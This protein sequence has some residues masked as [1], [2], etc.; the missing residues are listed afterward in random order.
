MKLYQF[1][2]FG[3]DGLAPVDV[4]E[5]GPGPRDVLVRW[6]AW[7]LNSRDLLLI[8]GVL[9]PGLPLPFTPVSDAAGEVVSVGKEV[10]TWKS[11]DR[12]VSHFF[13]DWQDG[14]GTPENRAAALA[15]SLPGLLAECSVLPERAL[16]PLPSHMSYA[17]GAT[18]PIAGVTAWNALF[19]TNQAALQPG[20]TVLLQGTGGVSIFA[21]Q[22]AHAAGLRTI[23]TSSSDEKLARARTL[24]ADATI[25]YRTTPA[26]AEQTRR[27]TGGRGVDLV[28]DIGGA[29][30]LNH[31]FRAARMGGSVAIVGLTGGPQVEIDV[32]QV[33]SQLIRIRGVSVGSRTELLAALHAMEVRKIHPIVDRQF[34]F[35]ETRAAFLHFKTGVHFGKIVIVSPNGRFLTAPS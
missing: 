34:G 9:A 19:P 8:E 2:R 31:S 10:T 26:W 14:E 28:V 3:I 17:E 29:S 1:S 5:T 12:V 33:F 6:Q 4:S 15:L 30:T 25:N 21:L 27:L 23:I 24:G 18:L 20:S 35:D 13:L 32:T 11:G 16:V 7:S 22:L